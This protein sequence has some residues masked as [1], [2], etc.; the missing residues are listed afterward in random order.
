MGRCPHACRGVGQRRL[1]RRGARRVGS[2]WQ[3]MGSRWSATGSSPTRARGQRRCALTTSNGG[4]GCKATDGDAP[5]A[6]AAVLA[7]RTGAGSRARGAGGGH[8]PW[9]VAVAGRWPHASR[10]ARGRPV[11]A[12]VGAHRRPLRRGP[13]G[14]GGRPRRGAGLWRRGAVTADASEPGECPARRA[15][16]DPRGAGRAGRRGQCR[17]EALLPAFDGWCAELAA[18]PVPDSLQHDDLHSGNVC[19]PGNGSARVIDWGDASWGCP[20]GTMLTTM[21]SVA[22]T[23][24][25]TS[26]DSP[27]VHLLCSGSATPT[28]SRSRPMPVTPIWCAASSSPVVRDVW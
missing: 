8:G 5:R 24:A 17:L 18:M 3:H 23:P 1:S 6:V 25:C 11:V 19:W 10:G 9:L 20:L 2:G 14:V 12:T 4:F 27:L 16:L 22:H 7:C 26:R 28:W 13:A 15:R 21:R